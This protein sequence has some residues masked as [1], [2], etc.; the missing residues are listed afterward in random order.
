MSLGKEMLDGIR[1]LHGS[2]RIT[3]QNEIH[4]HVHKMP[5]DNFG[6]TAEFDCMWAWDDDGR[7]E[8]TI[9]RITICSARHE[10]VMPYSMFSEES[11]A[12]LRDEIAGEIET[13]QEPQR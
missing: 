11:L 2:P 6:W 3:R 4:Q 13:S 8:V 12:E 10:L 7:A 1:E 5:L 9:Y